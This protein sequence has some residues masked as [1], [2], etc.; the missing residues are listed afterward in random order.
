MHKHK[1]KMKIKDKSKS[2]FL[3]MF[4]YV[5]LPLNKLISLLFLARLQTRAK[6]WLN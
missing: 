1:K 6:I 5:R 4:L 3:Y 2:M